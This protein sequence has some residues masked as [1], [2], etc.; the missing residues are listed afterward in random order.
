MRPNKIRITSKLSVFV[1]DILGTFVIERY[2]FRLTILKLGHFP[3][4]I[5]NQPLL[6][7]TKDGFVFRLMKFECLT[8]TLISKVLYAESP[9]S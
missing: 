1:N 9:K 4:W 5:I 6:I 3:W 8:K 2:V 7:N